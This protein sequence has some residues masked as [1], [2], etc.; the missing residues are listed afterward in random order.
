M[1]AN[2]SPQQ[3]QQQSMHPGLSQTEIEEWLN[4]IPVYT[5]TDREGQ[6]I[7]IEPT[8]A[9]KEDESDNTKIFN[10]YLSSQTAKATLQQ[11][12]IQTD[13]KTS[14][15]DSDDLIFSLGKI[16]FDLLMKK[17]KQ[18]E[19]DQYH[20]VASEKD[21]LGARMLLTMGPK[22]EEELMKAASAEEQ[23][24]IMDRINNEAPKF[25]PM[26]LNEIPVFMISQMRLKVEEKAMIPMYLSNEDMISTY[27]DFLENSNKDGEDQ[28]TEPSIQ[29]LELHEIVELM[30]KP[31]A[32]D[33]RS[34]M[35]MPPKEEEKATQ[36]V[37]KT[38]G[39]G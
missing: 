4:Y 26:S 3:Q 21:L 19:Q 20:L 8:V 14:D 30:E 1:A 18:D 32:F 24:R 28:Q 7:Y 33:F 23:K 27:H 13:D 22:E 16:W 36:P 39:E 34:V 31:C 25:K 29:L 37:R 10:F 2:L 6:F 15:I 12:K 11:L 17:K 38:F 35:L 5:I 9:K